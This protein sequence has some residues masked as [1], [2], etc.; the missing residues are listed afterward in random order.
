MDERDRDHDPHS[1]LSPNHQPAPLPHSQP[2]ILPHA[3]PVVLPV[4][5][6]SR[7]GYRHCAQLPHKRP[8]RPSAQLHPADTDRPQW[9]VNAHPPTGRPPRRPSSYVA[10]AL[11]AGRRHLR[12][13]ARQQGP[14]QRLAAR[15]REP[16]AFHPAHCSWQPIAV[17]PTRLVRQRRSRRELA[18]RGR[19][20]R[21][22]SRWEP[23]RWRGVA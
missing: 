5:P 22:Q 20:G 19:V 4:L 8:I 1:Y 15:A 3:Q 11:R 23:Q 2:V 9:S 13:P 21:A 12:E 14:R 17:H 18:E 7:R 16:V 6:R 10:A